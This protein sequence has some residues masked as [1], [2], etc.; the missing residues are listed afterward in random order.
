MMYKNEFTI[1]LFDKNTERQEVSTSEAK[2][3]IAKILIENFGIFA[4]TM[5]D[6]N[7]VYKMNSTGKIVFEPSIRVEI[8]TDEELTEADAIIENLKEALNQECIM[9]QVSIENIFF[10]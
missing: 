5:I 4:F 10:K 3:I 1:G 6:C 2:N 7:G 9:H 8:A